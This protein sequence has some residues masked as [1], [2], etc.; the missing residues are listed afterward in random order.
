M[1]F[2]Y[3]GVPKPVSIHL[4]KLCGE[5]PAKE[6]FFCQKCLNNGKYNF[7]ERLHIILGL[8]YKNKKNH[9]KSGKREKRF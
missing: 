9:A 1:S 3:R 8:F 7:T 4:C 2:G 5:N 6:L